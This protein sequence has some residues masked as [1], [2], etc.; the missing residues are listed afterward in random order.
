M[1]IVVD[2]SVLID[3]LRGD[4]GARDALRKA[5]G[6]GERL[7]ASVL[8]KVEILAGMRASEERVTRRLLD[9]LDLIGVDDAIAERAGILANH[10]LRSHPGVDPV[11]YVIAATAQHLD[12]ELWTRNLKHF[13]M[14]PGL[15]APY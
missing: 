15:S 1:A 11:D 6:A 4:Q 9:T 2:T 12:A 3:H 5:A 10:Y 8:T 13:P 7:A 14:F